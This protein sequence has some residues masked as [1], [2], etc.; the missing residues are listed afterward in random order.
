M[1]SN[2]SLCRQGYISSDRIQTHDCQALVMQQ[3]QALHPMKQQLKTLCPIVNPWVLITTVRVGNKQ[4][5][6]NSRLLLAR[7]TTLVYYCTAW[8]PMAEQYDY[9]R[10]IKNT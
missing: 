5:V 6:T 8:L 4:M 2:K 10:A 3:L 9:I 7:I 1:S